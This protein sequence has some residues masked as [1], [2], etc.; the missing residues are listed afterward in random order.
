MATKIDF[1]LSCPQGRFLFLQHKANRYYRRALGDECDDLAVSTWLRCERKF[2]QVRTSPAAWLCV[3]L[4]RQFLN[5]LRS[6]KWLLPG[7][8]AVGA[9]CDAGCGDTNGCSVA[10]L[11]VG[12]DLIERALRQ[13]PPKQREAAQLRVD[14]AGKTPDRWDAKLDNAF[15]EAQRKLRVM[16]DIVELATQYRWL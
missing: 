1:D 15:R 10:D 16:P 8:D 12:E 13:L 11:V 4:R 6:R 3:S 9:M 2:D 14:S 5:Y 7:D